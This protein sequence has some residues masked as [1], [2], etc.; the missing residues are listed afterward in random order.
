MGNGSRDLPTYVA[1]PDPVGLP[2]TGKAA[3]T[4]GFLPALQSSRVDLVSAM[5]D[6][7]PRGTARGR[8]RAGLVVAQV[9]VS[10][11][12][13]VGS[14]LVSRSLEAAPGRAGVAWGTPDAIKRDVVNARR[15]A[16]IVIVAL[17]AGFE[18]TAEPNSI[19]RDL[20][21]AAI[22]AGAA[23]VLGAHPHVMQGLE[24]YKGALIAYSL[25]NFIFD[26]DDAD[27]A[28]YGLPSVLT[29]ILRV[30]LEGGAVSGIEIYPAIINRT[31]FRP[32]PVSGVAA[33]PVYD[34][35]Y[36]LTDALNR[37]AR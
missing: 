14:G 4:N 10:L 28:Q 35:L 30:R 31:D 36:R 21:H 9:A 17:H 8:L 15:T 22:D 37:P 20:A 19:Q 34:R 32:E 25:G 1:L 2:W 5:S 33:R 6:V 16:D 29:L 23:L 13:L 26:L 11:L 12:L 27:L 24:F 3:W 18:Y 7:S